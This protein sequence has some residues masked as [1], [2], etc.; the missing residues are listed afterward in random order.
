MKDFT[1]IINQALT[2]LDKMLSAR[3]LIALM[4]VASYCYM[5]IVKIEPPSAFYTMLGSVV[6]HYFMIDR[7]KDASDKS[8]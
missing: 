3:K 6:T 1:P 2:T 7:T 5:C 4:F 8:K